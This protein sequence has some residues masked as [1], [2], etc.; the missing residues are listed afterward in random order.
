MIFDRVRENLRGMRRDTLDDVVNRAVNQT[1]GRT[2]ITAGTTLL[3]VTALFLFGGEVLRGF[4][5][6]MLVGVITGTYSSVFIA[7][8]IVTF[9]KRKAATRVPAAA[10]ASASGPSRKKAGGK[11]K[12]S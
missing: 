5:F 8:T 9:W 6:T 12:A 2:I 10:P 7:S 3:S 1:L 4:A 11:V